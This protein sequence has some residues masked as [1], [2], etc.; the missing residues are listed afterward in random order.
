MYYIV[1]GATRFVRGT[2]RVNRLRRR[3]S[4]SVEQASADDDPRK[5]DNGFELHLE[6]LVYLGAKKRANVIACY[7]HPHTICL[8]HLPVSL[9]CL[10][11]VVVRAWNFEI[12]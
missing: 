1:L 11:R 7:I 2:R 8:W 4:S 12:E 5:G 9:L 6:E 3:F 10:I